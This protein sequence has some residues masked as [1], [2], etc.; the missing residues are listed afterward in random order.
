M[1]NRETNINKNLSIAI[2]VFVIFEIIFALIATILFFIGLIQK[3][4]FEFN[5]KES[6]IVPKE[7]IFPLLLETSELLF[8][9]LSA[10]ILI[11]SILSAIV[12]YNFYKEKEIDNSLYIKL[13]LIGM[14]ISLVS[15]IAAIKYIS[16]PLI[17]I[18]QNQ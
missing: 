5:N 6:A 9:F 3:I 12:I 14:F 16:R 4:N 15:M 1:K 8:K 10:N 2:I 18:E 11:V 13:F 7:E 17:K